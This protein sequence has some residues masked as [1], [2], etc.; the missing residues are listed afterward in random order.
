MEPTKE[1]LNLML[2]SE[3]V[4][5]HQCCSEKGPSFLIQKM[6]GLTSGI[7]HVLGQF[8]SETPAQSKTFPG[9]MRK[10]EHELVYEKGKLT[11]DFL[12]TSDEKNCFV[13]NYALETEA[14]A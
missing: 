3:L 1:K 7:N 6:K 10:V 9:G 8:K 2:A 14:K 13:T 4:N 11:F 5:D 12:F